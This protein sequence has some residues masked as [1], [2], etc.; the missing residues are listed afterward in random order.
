MWGGL[1]EA[2]GVRVQP[3]APSS[4]PP[5]RDEAATA[6]GTQPAPKRAPFSLFDFFGGLDAALGVSVNPKQPSP[7]AG[8][9][10]QVLHVTPAPTQTLRSVFQPGRTVDNTEPPLVVLVHGLESHSG[11]W[12]ALMSRFAA[13]KEPSPSFLAVDLRGHGLTP[14][15]EELDFGPATLARDVMACVTAHNAS[16]EKFILV[17]HSM[18]A[19]VATRLVADFPNKVSHLVIEDMDARQFD[20]TKYFGEQ[21][22]VN[23]FE[24]VKARG[25]CQ[26]GESI[27]EV[28]SALVGA[29]GPGTFQKERIA[30]FPNPADCLLPLFQCTT[31]TF[32]STGNCYIRHIRTF[33]PDY[34]E[35]TVRPDYSTTQSPIQYTRT[36]D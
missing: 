11:T 35:C 30:R 1:D 4:T 15:G 31:V 26:S 23:G 33:R 7:S 28:A 27:H 18:G 34:S 14:V 19:R 24:Y 13:S 9:A 21:W 5:T 36:R 32:T 22:R 25:F 6:S 8:A 3:N 12:D 20:G 10:A 29:A 17:G 2:L 16:A